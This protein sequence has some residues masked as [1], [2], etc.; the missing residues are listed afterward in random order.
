MIMPTLPGLSD[1]LSLLIVEGAWKSTVILGGVIFIIRLLRR[2]SASLRQLVLSAG[3]IMLLVS[4]L[5]APLLPRWT[6]S[7]PDWITAT[8][9]EKLAPEPAAA[10]MSRVSS[11]PEDGQPRADRT[12]PTVEGRAQSKGLMQL[13]PGLIPFIWLA[14]VLSA[15]ARLGIGLH[16]LRHLL[17]TSSA[18][19]HE[20]TYNQ[21]RSEAARLGLRRRITVLLNRAITVPITWGVL[22]PVILLPEGFER[23]PADRSRAVLLHELSHVQRH[24]FVI[25]FLAEITCAVLWFQ[26]LAWMSRRQLL[27]EQERA[28]DDRVLAM[29]EKASSYARLLLEWQE[30]LPGRDLLAVGMAQRSSLERRLRAIL[31]HGLKRDRVTMPRA[32]T[33]WLL[34]VGLALPLAAL[35]FTKGTVPSTRPLMRI[36]STSDGTGIEAQ[37]R[38]KAN[39]ARETATT[40]ESFN[41]ESGGSD[42]RGKEQASTRRVNMQSSGPFLMS[43]SDEEPAN[44]VQRPQHEP[45]GDEAPAAGASSGNI[46]DPSGKQSILPE[47]IPAGEIRAPLGRQTVA[48]KQIV[49]T[50]RASG[51]IADSSGGR[52]I[53]P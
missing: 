24:D 13:L 12:T 19:H 6:V 10:S 32:L 16:G 37:P 42:R 27:E 4:M 46:R 25:R 30:R 38:S 41:S 26:P 51:R 31:D 50:T 45:A 23:L 9:Y 49:G 44:V 22:R 52:V 1:S 14:G 36:G 8:T 2:R 20:E 15:L 28:C 48:P 17:Q 29:G 43:A 11:K 34:A 40:T 47:K 5:T 39:E 7:T 18:L 35:G 33:V 3:I 21:V 53:A